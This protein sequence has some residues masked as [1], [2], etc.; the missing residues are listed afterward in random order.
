MSET[1]NVKIVQDAYAAFGKGDIP[2]LLESLSENVEWHVPGEGVIPEG[3]TYHGRDG[4]ARFFQSLV[5]NTEFL[6]FEPREFVAQGDRVIALGWYRGKATATGR[7]FESHWAMSF[8]LQDGKVRAF[9]EFTDTS[10][11]GQAFAGSASATA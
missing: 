11:I 3:G 5:K 8:L 6:A 10:T 1:E 4:V 2:A 9:Q 7:I